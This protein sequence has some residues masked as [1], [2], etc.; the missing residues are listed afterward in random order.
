MTTTC[1]TSNLIKSLLWQL[2]WPW[3]RFLT[4]TLQLQRDKSELQTFCSSRLNPS[5]N[6]EF[7][8]KGIRIKQNINNKT[9]SKYSII[10]LST[11]LPTDMA[12]SDR[13][14]TMFTL[15][16]VW[17]FLFFRHEKFTEIWNSTSTFAFAGKKMFNPTYFS[18]ELCC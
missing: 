2:S 5:E 10:R 3:K 8:S 18:S 17:K 9:G 15:G 12:T 7:K 11:R 13:Q 6:I 16:E 1:E 14:A 4:A